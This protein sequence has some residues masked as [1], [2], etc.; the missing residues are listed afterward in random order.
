MDEHDIHITAFSRAILLHLA[1]RTSGKNKHCQF[2]KQYSQVSRSCTATAG[3]T[4]ANPNP[5]AKS[6]AMGKANHINA[7]VSR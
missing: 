6:V 2:C 5:E 4:V 3:Q 1:E 7:V